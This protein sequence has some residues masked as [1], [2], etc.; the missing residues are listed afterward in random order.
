[1][2]EESMQSGLLRATLFA[3]T[4]HREQRRKGAGATPYVNHVV[5]VATLLATVAKV[6][7][8]AILQAALLHDTVEDTETTFEHIEE[9]FGSDVRFLVEEM[10]DDKTLPKAERKRLQVE[11]APGMSS[12]GKLIKIADKISNIRDIIHRPPPDWSIERRRA[13]VAWGE[14]VVAGCRGVNEALEDL[15]DQVVE[16]AKTTLERES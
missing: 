4:Q 6:E 1:M 8:L 12:R 5:D 14:A 3:A 9:L 11:H 10:T 16:E 2:E 15:F 7:D 13:Y